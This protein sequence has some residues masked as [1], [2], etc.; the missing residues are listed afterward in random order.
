MPNTLLSTALSTAL[1]Y[2]R[3]EYSEESITPRS[4]FFPAYPVRSCLAGRQ[5]T[6]GY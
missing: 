1:S 4:R 5:A 6:G 3:S 2:S